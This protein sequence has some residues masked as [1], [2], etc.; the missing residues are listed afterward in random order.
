MHKYMYYVKVRFVWDENKD[1]ENQKKHGVSFS[2]AQY[3]FEDKNRIIAEDLKHSTK[4]EKRYFCFGMIENGI[5]T[6]RFT[7]RKLVIRI[8]GAGFQRERKQ[9]YEEENNL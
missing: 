4:T 2:E 3:A 8:F 9:K 1:I 7:V 6:V 5:L